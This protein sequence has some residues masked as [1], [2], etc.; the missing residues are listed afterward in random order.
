MVHFPPSRLSEADRGCTAEARLR[1][2]VA[3][4]EADCSTGEGVAGA[5]DVEAGPL[6]VEMG[7][8]SRLGVEDFASDDWY[9][10]P[11]ARPIAATPTVPV[12]QS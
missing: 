8:A 10:Q 9:R 3:G 2:R 6:D 11:N 12:A 7:G 5:I 1:R 4:A